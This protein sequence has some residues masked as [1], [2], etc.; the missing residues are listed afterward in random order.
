MLLSK[1]ILFK[2]L[3][4]LFYLISFFKELCLLYYLLLYKN[5]NNQ[6][7]TFRQRKTNRIK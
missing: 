2:Y 3:N 7:E 4:F 5:L 1:F 6:Y